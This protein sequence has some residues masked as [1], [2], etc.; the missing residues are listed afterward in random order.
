MSVLFWL[1]LTLFVLLFLCV[2]EIICPPSPNKKSKTIHSI[3]EAF[4]HYLTGQILNSGS[5]MLTLCQNC[6][7][8]LFCS[9]GHSE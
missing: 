8:R 2:F 5:A 7:I 9:M 6:V 4:Q 1:F 3:L